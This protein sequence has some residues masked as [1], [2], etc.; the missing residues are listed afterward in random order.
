M[1]CPIV[2]QYMMGCLE[3]YQ[4]I[5]HSGMVHTVGCPRYAANPDRQS[6]CNLRVPCKK[7]CARRPT[8]QHLAVIATNVGYETTK[9]I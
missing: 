7:R 1:G 4:Y 8:F 3:E 2:S 6:A 9:P 5:R